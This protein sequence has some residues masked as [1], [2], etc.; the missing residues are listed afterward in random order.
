M[1]KLNSLKLPQVNT[2]QV[3]VASFWPANELFLV[4]SCQKCKCDILAVTGVV[5]DKVNPWDL[6]CFK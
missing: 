4:Y 6:F 5:S 1:A 2:T 3:I